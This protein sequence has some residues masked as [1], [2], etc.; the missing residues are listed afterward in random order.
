ME[1]GSPTEFAYNFA[2]GAVFEKA[3][4]TLNNVTFQNTATAL[5]SECLFLAENV[6]S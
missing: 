4:T 1:T 3:L 6:I 5:S 2:R